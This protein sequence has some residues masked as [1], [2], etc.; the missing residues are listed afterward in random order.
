M[1]NSSKHTIL[2]YNTIIALKDTLIYIQTVSKNS[3]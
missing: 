3:H 2:K 1:F